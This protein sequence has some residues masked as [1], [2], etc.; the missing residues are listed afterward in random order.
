VLQAETPLGVAP[1]SLRRRTGHRRLRRC[2]WRAGEAAQEFELALAKARGLGA[3][4]FAVHIVAIM[5][6]KKR[7]IKHLF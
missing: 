2:C 4:G 6:Q 1:Q 7:K 5:L 3:F